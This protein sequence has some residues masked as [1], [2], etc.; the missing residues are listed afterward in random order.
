LRPYYLFERTLSTFFR[1]ENFMCLIYRSINRVLRGLLAVSF[2][3]LSSAIHAAPNGADVKAIRYPAWIEQNG[4][5]IPLAPGMAIHAAD[6][7]VSGDDARVLFELPDGSEMKLGQK[8]R[9]SISKLA[10]TSVPGGVNMDVG[11]SLLVG[12]F[13]YA[14]SAIS[15]LTSKRNVTLKLS[16]ATI[17]IRGTDFWAMTDKERD[18]A[19][20]FEGKIEVA[21]A[22]QE[23]VP[24]DKPTAFW[25]HYFD[26]PP[27]PAGNATAEELAQ[28]LGWVEI[29][30]GTG[31]AVQG[32]RWRLIAGAEK[33][34]GDAQALGKALR[35][36]GYPAIIMKNYGLH[37]VRINQFATRA[38]AEAQLKKLQA[39]PGLV[40][41][42]PKIIVTR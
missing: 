9:F 18:A 14:T 40:G 1:L 27:Q 35:E 12:R 30:P 37:E 32:G 5:K 11:L 24:L 17:G 15:K 7:V 21:T 6:A 3:L 31:V 28:F 38:D 25:N 8:A 10:T 39:L 26:K 23:I 36:Q 16:T 2:L 29:A 13:R 41:N 34:A 19:C 33:N 4:Q 20:L 42:D 22:E